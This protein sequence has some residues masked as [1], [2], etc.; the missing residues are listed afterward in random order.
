MQVVRGAWRL[1]AVAG[2]VVLAWLVPAATADEVMAAGVVFADANGNGV[3]DAGEAGIPDVRVSNGREI[4]PT[5]ADGR[6]RLPVSDDTIIF[7]IKP[8]GWMTPVDA[9]HLPRFYYIHKPNGSPESKSPF[10]GVA[11][12]GPLPESIDFAL[13]QQEEPARFEL[14]IFGDTQ[15]SSMG[16][17]EYLA[18]D[19]VE[20]LIGT[21]A[22]FGVSL[23][24]L[25]GDNLD[26]HEPICEVV[27]RVGIPWYN[28]L[29]NHDMNYHASAD[30][31][32]NESF[33][34]VFGPSCYAFVY[35]DVH[36]L[37]LDDPFSLEETK[38][39]AGL[40]ER[41]LDF[42]E[43]YLREV[44][45]EALV[46]AMAHI[47]FGELPVEE[48]DRLFALLGDRPNRLLLSAHYHFGRHD[49]HGGNGSDAIHEIIAPTTCGSWWTGVPDEVGLPHTTM[50]DGAPNGWLVATCEGN[51]CAVR[52]VPA[53]RPANYQMNIYA[54]EQV[55]AVPNGDTEVLVNVFFGSS[56]SVVEMQVDDG[57]WLPLSPVPSEDPSYVAMKK[58]EEAECP[59][60][61][62]KLPK[63]IVCPHMWRGVL[64]PT[65]GPGV[66]V[67]HVR[68]TDVFGQRYDGRRLV[69]VV[70]G[71]PES[72]AGR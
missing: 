18:H 34:R 29:G 61:G 31:Y 69:R 26:L 60:P 39:R 6:Y 24:D 13:R 38:Y 22:A 59:P 5:D 33:E 68:T 16:D 44:P 28:V 17:I 30:E 52:F 45:R 43:N 1:A 72:Q 64:P 51:R 11:P 15:P 27:G 66:H 3:R 42:V 20:Q 10:A 35:S 48:R 63:T 8:T 25:V 70:P 32:S 19:I 49:F 14:L 21:T 58:M 7:V 67:I 62:R 40:G 4:V 9:N 65:L 37:V 71:G 57:E 41:Q 2:V 54:P 56:R 50:R 46:V 47:P 36:F 55:P 12:T 23:G 53:R